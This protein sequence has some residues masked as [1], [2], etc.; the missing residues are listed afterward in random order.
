M[1]IECKNLLNFVLLLQV[2]ARS[3][4]KKLISSQ[5]KS[6]LGHFGAF[7]GHRC[8]V[9]RNL[10]LLSMSDVKNLTA[11]YQNTQETLHKDFFP[12]SVKKCRKIF[13]FS[14]RKSIEVYF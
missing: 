5:N 2:F 1:D 13:A 9:A 3:S 10:K 4:K 14:V 6:V 12:F 7:Y 8:H 11:H